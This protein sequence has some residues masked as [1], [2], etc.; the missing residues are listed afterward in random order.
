MNDYCNCPKLLFT[1]ISD[2][3]QH[4]KI[5]ATMGDMV[6]IDGSLDNEEKCNICDKP[7]KDCGTHYERDNK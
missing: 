2:T 3:H 4:L 5:K 6:L 1:F 7:L